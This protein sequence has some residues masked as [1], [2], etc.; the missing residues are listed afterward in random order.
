MRRTVRARC[1]R[2]PRCVDPCPRR[3]PEV[4]RRR[5]RGHREDV[6][7]RQAGESH[8]VADGAVHRQGRPRQVRLARHRH[9]SRLVEVHAEAAQHVVAWRTSGRGRGI[10]DENRARGRLGA[11]HGLDRRRRQVVPIHD[12]PS[13]QLVGG[14]LLPEKVRMPRQHLRA[15]VA[16]MRRH[17]RAGRHRVA[18]L[19]RRGG[20]VADGHAHAV[21]DELL[22][23]RQCARHFGRD[24]SP[25][26]CGHR[27]PPG[28][29]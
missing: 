24:R 26:G 9:T 19:L 29:A 6:G 21:F 11:H 20:R 25:G 1:R 22:D 27:P 10:G 8:G 7:Q 12:Q 5:R 28:D 4:A 3:D 18:H 2:I 23:Q 16:K 14:Q 13:H 17:R 15:A